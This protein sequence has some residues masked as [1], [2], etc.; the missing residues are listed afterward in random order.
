M[1]EESV[2]TKKSDAKPEKVCSKCGFAGVTKDFK[3]PLNHAWILSEITLWVIAIIILIEDKGWGLL[4]LWPAAVVTILR[5]SESV[6]CPVCKAKRSD[7]IPAD[8]PRGRELI[9]GSDN[10]TQ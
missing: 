10:Q 1:N 7:Q 4:I 9:K 6:K 8:S 3:T 2:D 5:Y